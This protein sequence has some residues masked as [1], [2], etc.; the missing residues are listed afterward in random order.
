MI[1]VRW[2]DLPEK[3]EIKTRKRKMKDGSFKEYQYKEKRKRTNKAITE[4]KDSLKKIPLPLRDI[5]KAYGIPMNKLSIDYTKYRPRNGELTDE[6]IAYL[7]ADL[8]IPALALQN[9]II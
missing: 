3:D 7:K 1:T 5:P 8:L 6:E 2:K 9:D 4:F